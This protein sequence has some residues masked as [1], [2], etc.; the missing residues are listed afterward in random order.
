MMVPCFTPT[1]GKGLKSPNTMFG[2]EFVK[3]VWSIL[4][5]FLL[6]SDLQGSGQINWPHLISN[7]QFE[8]S[9][10]VLINLLLSV[11]V[12]TMINSFEKK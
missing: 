11:C 5:T 1:W 4:V 3:S 7:A 8:V 12:L 9:L 10:V 6:V 2:P